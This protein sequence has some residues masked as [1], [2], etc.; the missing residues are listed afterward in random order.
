MLTAPA[1]PTTSPTGSPPHGRTPAS[2][3]RLPF[4]RRQQLPWVAAGVVLIVGCAL[5]FALIAARGSAARQVLVVTGSLP[6]G[7]VLTAGDLATTTLREQL[8]ASVP[9]G[10]E[11][12]ELGRPLAAGLLAGSLLTPAAVGS[13]AGVSAG[14]AIVGLGLKAGQYPP[15]LGPGDR[16]QIIDTTPDASA[17]SGAGGGAGPAAIAATVVAVSP[18]PEGAAATDVVSLQVSQPDAAAVARLS[19][20]GQ[21]S[22]VLL[23]PGS[24]P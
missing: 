3:R 21:A 13:G 1:P 19:A 24:A 14:Q 12:A 8:V 2:A 4:Q 17:G 15:M 7:H 5:L 18:A 10:Q 6:A 23:A 22:L 16:V 9:A 11:P 20:L